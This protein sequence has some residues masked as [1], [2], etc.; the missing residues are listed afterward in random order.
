MADRGWMAGH[1]QVHAN[2][3]PHVAGLL[4]VDGDWPGPMTLSAGWYRA[5]VRPWN[6]VVIDPMVRLERGG[7]EFLISV[8]NH[9]RDLGLG[10]VYSPAL[11]PTTTR[12][13]RR[14]GFAEYA[15][16]SVMEKPLSPQEANL[17]EIELESSAPDW[18]PVLEIDRAAF[19][20][21]WGMSKQ[22][23]KD[24]FATNKRSTLITAGSE[25]PT[26]YALLG[27]QWGVSYLHRIAVRPD[28]G[29]QGI[30]RRLLQAAFDWAYKAGAR[31]M[32]L[33][34]RAVNDRAIRLY[35]KNGF[36]KTPTELQV[37]SLQMNRGVS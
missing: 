12:I 10:T 5:H 26:G 14:S 8:T 37:F 9:L 27:A 19:E 6:E 24:A 31:S 2:T 28:L 34:V 7:V 16:L 18:D 23:L 20:G 4:R 30:G 21:F 36:V 22:G 32:V 3:L 15:S 11:F 33:N 29:G 13:W 17:S 25:P 35:E 1:K